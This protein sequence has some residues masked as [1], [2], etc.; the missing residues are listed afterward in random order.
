MINGI[1]A[2]HI[3]RSRRDG[4]CVTIPSTWSRPPASGPPRP[5]AG[6]SP[7]SAADNPGA[8]SFDSVASEAGV[9][10]SWLYAQPDL[11]AQ[12]EQLRPRNHQRPATAA[13]PERQRSTG[14]SLL[15]RLEAASD[16]IRR[17]DPDNQQ[18][19]AA[20]AQALGEHRQATSPGAAH[21][22]ATRRTTH[23]ARISNHADTVRC[24]AIK[25]CPRH[26]AAGQSDQSIADSR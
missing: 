20:L 24:G 7:P 14:T 21:P 2:D 13:P 22:A 19:H 5:G 17:L 16:G 8:I 15:R 1:Q 26:I 9:S 11:R 12:I 18:L 10:R 4:R 23:L 25:T 6:R 3:K